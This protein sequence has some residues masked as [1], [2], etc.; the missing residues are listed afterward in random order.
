MIKTQQKWHQWEMF[1]FTSVADE[2]TQRPDPIVKE[3]VFDNT[4]KFVEWMIVIQS[5][6]PSLNGYIKLWFLQWSS[7]SLN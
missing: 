3:K 5:N 2:N 6:P 7:P 4:Q 1:K